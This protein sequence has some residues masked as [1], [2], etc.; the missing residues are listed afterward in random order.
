MRILIVED[1]RHIRQGVMNVLN[2]EGFDTLEAGNLRKALDI[3]RAGDVDAI[4]S[5]IR[6]PD[7]DGFDL[8]HALKARNDP[9][10]CILMTAFGNRDIANQA[11]KE[12]AYDYISKPIRFDELLARLFC[13][14]ERIELERRLQSMAAALKDEGKLASMGNSAAMRQVRF[15]AEKAAAARSPV[16]IRGERG[17]GKR[18]LAHLIHMT[19][20]RAAEPFVQLSCASIP[21][22]L[23]ERELFG[24][25]RGAFPGADRGYE[26]I[27]SKAGR[28]TL[29]LDEVS[30]LPR[31]IQ[32]A[33]LRVLDDGCFQPLGETRRQPFQARIITATDKD[34]RN[35]TLHGRFREDLFFCLDVLHIDIP[36]LRERREDIVPLAVSILEKLAA[37]RSIRIAP[38][39]ARQCL[40][41]KSQEWPGNVREL[42]NT[43]ERALLLARDGRLDLPPRRMVEGRTG[44]T[45]AEATANFERSLIL[46]TI[47]ACDGDKEEASRR[48][49]IGLSTLYRKLGT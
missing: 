44:A 1:E 30:E 48:L 41:L 2:E 12:G 21:E 6:L 20:E 10:P 49:G 29:F 7:G 5:D 32:A 45:L 39:D 27:L 9:V 11:L 28:G 37:D 19:S 40:W 46:Q 42:R 38:L 3:L 36:P 4:L 31:I 26:G 24:Y 43:L 13:L 14:Q 22:E 23:M 47:E 17:V 33:L 34:L 15:L 8:L 16:L 18:R 35:E 25:R